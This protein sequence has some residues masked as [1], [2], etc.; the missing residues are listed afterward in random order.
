MDVGLFFHRATIAVYFVPLLI[1]VTIAYFIASPF[2][3]VGM[4][5]EG[6]RRHWND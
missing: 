6:A 3:A 4:V 2:I 1:I 5:F